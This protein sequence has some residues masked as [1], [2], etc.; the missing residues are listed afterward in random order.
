[1]VICFIIVVA[2]FAEFVT[3]YFSGFFPSVCVNKHYKN[4]INT[5]NLTMT[6]KCGICDE[7]IGKTQSSLQCQTCPVWFHAACANVSDKE[8][9]MVKKNSGLGYFCAK[10]KEDQTGGDDDIRALHKKFDDGREDFNSIK[11]AFADAVSDIK[12]EMNS[13]FRELKADIVNC[14]TNINKVESFT[15]AK[16]SNLEIEN[17]VLHRRLN[18]PDIVIRGLP[19][20]LEDLVVAVVALGAFFNIPIAGHDISHACYINKKGLILVKFNNVFVRDKIMSEYFK[21][22][23][24][25]VS[26][27]IDGGVADGVESRVFLNDHYTPAASRLNVACRKL[28]IDKKIKKYRLF[29]ADKLKAKITLLDGNEM[30]V[31]DAA[32]CAV[33]QN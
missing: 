16:I 14:T 19:A 30:E 32:G 31:N 29:N 6:Y 15:S 12:T 26:D 9:T 23:T 10:C 24:L 1:M 3:V 17:H 28:L 2:D 25:K 7:N 4:K 20:G 8:H 13:C 11:G 5:N 18:R 22:R 27:I 33:L 21:T